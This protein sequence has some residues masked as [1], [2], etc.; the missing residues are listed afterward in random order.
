MVILVS[1][2]LY[3]LGRGGGMRVKQAQCGK[4]MFQPGNRAHFGH[5]EGFLGFLVITS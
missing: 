5:F 3:F 4:L 2:E 1:E